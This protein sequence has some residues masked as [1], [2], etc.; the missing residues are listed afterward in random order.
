MTSRWVRPYAPGRGRWLIIG[1]ELGG[2]ALLLWS[3]VRMYQLGPIAA[4]WL[5]GALTVAWLAGSWRILRM[6]VYVSDHGVFVRGLTGSRVLPWSRIDRITVDDVVHRFAGLEIPSGRT[7]VIACDGD[8]VNTPLWAQGIDFRFRPGVFR[9]V[10]QGLRAH[11]AA[12]RA[13]PVTT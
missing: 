2:L 8:A 4:A 6:G 1:W 11:H 3:T 12:A 9:Q 10:Y 5:G 13:V 7:V